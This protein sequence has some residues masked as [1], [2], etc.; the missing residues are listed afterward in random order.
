MKPARGKTLSSMMRI[1]SNGPDEHH[2][3]LFPAA[4]LFLPTSQGVAITICEVSCKEKVL[5]YGE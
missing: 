4:D 5:N 3:H 1:D 2:F